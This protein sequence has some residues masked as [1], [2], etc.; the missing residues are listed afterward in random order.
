MNKVI[1][2]FLISMGFLIVIAYPFSVFA[3]ERAANTTQAT[4]GFTGSFPSKEKPD[5]NSPKNPQIDSKNK[6]LPKT[7]AKSSLAIECIG[8]GLINLIIGLIYIKRNKSVRYN[9]T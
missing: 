9:L 3:Q 2:T 1:K 6:E 4:V 7:G 8:V 5:I